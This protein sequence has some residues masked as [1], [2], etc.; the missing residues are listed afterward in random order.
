MFN[1]FLFAAV[2]GGTIFIFQFVLALVGMAPKISISSTTFR[3][4]STFRKTCST[5]QAQ[6]TTDRHRCSESF[7]FERSWQP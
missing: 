1:V 7:R 2:I 5:T 3:T 6:W 4:I